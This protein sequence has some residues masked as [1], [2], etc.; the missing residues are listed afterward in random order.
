M[1]TLL[2]ISV[3][4][5]TSYSFALNCSSVGNGNWNNPLTWSCGVVPSP[6]DTI[7]ISV[8]HTVTVSLNTDLNGAPVV[9]FIDGIL[10]FDSPGAKL[11]LECGSVII[12]SASGEIRDSGNGTPSHSIRI[13]G[14]DVWTGSDGSVF[15]PLV[16]IGA[17][18]SI[19]L[20]NFT[21]ELDRNQLRFNW[22]TA[23][24]INN[25][26]FTIEGSSD[27]LNW[28]S[29]G[30]H[31]GSGNSNELV[32]YEM[33]LSND[34]DNKYFRLRQT[35]YDGTST[36]S[37]VISISNI[38][39]SEL[40]VF[41]NPMSSDFL[42]IKTNMGNYNLRMFS[43]TGDLVYQIEGQNDSY[44]RIDGLYFEEGAYLVELSNEN[45]VVRTKIIKN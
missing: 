4:I 37:N 14:A 11:R 35:D 30:M 16:I 32:E 2:F 29:L 33:T 10:L 7:T 45:E 40:S 41:P 18:L 24:E 31:L 36:L 23:N 43:M 3:L 44:L 8:G 38:I 9:I 27:N 5:S 12:L 26:Y 19:E 20:I 13:C 42:M 15:G 28:V 21:A 39:S 17:P 25:D 34:A 1:K 6:G 22:S